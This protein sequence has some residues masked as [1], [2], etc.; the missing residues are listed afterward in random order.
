MLV[1]MSKSGPTDERF[2]RVVGRRSRPEPGVPPSP[3]ARRA[4]SEMARYRT[5][6]PKGIFFYR[7]HQEANRDSERWLL[8][9]IVEKQRHG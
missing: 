8:D 3:Q 7:S 5:R 2:L 9:A 6:A 4:M 1:E